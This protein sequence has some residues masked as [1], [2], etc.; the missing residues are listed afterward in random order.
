M[1][2]QRLLP[3]RPHLCQKRIFTDLDP[4]ALVVG[5]MPMKR[6]ELVQEHQVDEGLYLLHGKKM[7]AT[8]EHGPPVG[9]PRLVGD[10]QS[11]QPE[12]F[13]AGLFVGTPDQ[14]LGKG[15]KPPPDSGG[16]TAADRNPFGGNFQHILFGS[17]FSVDR[18]TDIGI[19]GLGGEDDTGQR[20]IGDDPPET[21]GR[22][23]DTWS[24]RFTK[25]LLPETGHGFEF[26]GSGKHPDFRSERQDTPR[27]FGKKRFGN[28]VDGR[29]G[30][31]AAEAKR[32]A[33]DKTMQ[34]L[35]FNSGFIST[36]NALPSRLRSPPEV[37][38][39]PQGLPTRR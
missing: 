3:H 13:T 26:R 7:P 24:V 1:P 39:R 30:R 29:H 6:V 20:R 9:E 22:L 10:S 8:V 36:D 19:A 23:A 35:H 33:D 25:R 37:P 12:R 16:R 38:H 27:L 34:F 15:L 21:G 28:D 31:T 5:K 14:H 11:G 18:E 32:A 4:P 2:D 17:Q